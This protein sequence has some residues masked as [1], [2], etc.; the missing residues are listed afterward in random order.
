LCDGDKFVPTFEE[1]GKRQSIANALTTGGA[2]A[3][4]LSVRTVIP[5]DES[6]FNEPVD[7]S[8]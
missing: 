3:I 6:E 1:G 2:N 4:A 8:T 5:L 7:V